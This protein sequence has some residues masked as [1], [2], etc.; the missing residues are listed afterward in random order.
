MTFV[1]AAALGATALG[2]GVISQVKQ[3][4]S[5]ITTVSEL[6][7]KLRDAEKMT[8][9]AEY[10]VFDGSTAT[11]VQQPPNAA[12][13]GKDGRFIVTADSYYLCSPEKKV[14]T[15]Q[16]SPS[17]GA[18]LDAA[19]AGLIPAVTGEGFISAPIALGLLVAASVT[20]GAHVDKSEKTIAGQHATCVKVTGIP[21]AT[22]AGAGDVKDFSTCVTDKGL[23]GSFEG[24]QNDG[25]RAGVEL[26]S[27]K[28][29]ADAKAFQP[30]AGAKIV[31]VQQI[32]PK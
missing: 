6:A 22:N 30:P 5:N 31:D 24:T 9:T 14:L 20:P 3:A 12:F 26:T 29:T 13:V 28:D 8:F 16:K 32:Q 4:A 11:V 27:F 18:S 23:L 2:C 21:Q 17:D 25:K 15:C 10:R 1:A 19:S 7:D